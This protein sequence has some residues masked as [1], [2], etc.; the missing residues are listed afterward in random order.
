M[1][2]THS[3]FVEKT[4]RKRSPIST[5]DRILGSKSAKECSWLCDRNNTL[6]TCKSSLEWEGTRHWITAPGVVR[7]HTIGSRLV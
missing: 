7:K 4:K 3:L 5:Y 2:Y 6:R 1:M